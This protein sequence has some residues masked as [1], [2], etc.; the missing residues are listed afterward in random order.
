MY[1]QTFE[2]VIKKNNISKKYGINLMTSK[3]FWCPPRR[4]RL[5]SIPQTQMIVS[6]EKSRRS[7]THIL[8][9]KFGNVIKKKRAHHESLQVQVVKLTSH[10]ALEAIDISLR[11][12]TPPN[13][14]FT[15]LIKSITALSG[16]WKNNLDAVET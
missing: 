5:I 13:L 7:S 9:R 4:P 10:G 16:S 15:E 1:R 14:G 12:K 3:K 6:T 11:D 8:T 2:T